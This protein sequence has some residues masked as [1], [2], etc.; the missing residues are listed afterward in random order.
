[1]SSPPPVQK[2]SAFTLHAIG[3]ALFTMLVL[4]L[5]LR[6]VFTPIDL[7]V[8]HEAV[9]GGPLSFAALG[10]V[11]YGCSLALLRVC[12]LSAFWG[13][14]YAM[15]SWVLFVVAFYPSAPRRGIM[16]RI[17]EPESYEAARRIFEHLQLFGA[18]AIVS[19]GLIQAVFLWYAIQQLR[20]GMARR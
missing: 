12:V 15:S 4:W 5:G 8:Y 1:M 11:F 6:A 18:V 20:S 3:A 10:F 7:F 13:A 16:R 19:F 14:I 2:S 17:A 9:Y